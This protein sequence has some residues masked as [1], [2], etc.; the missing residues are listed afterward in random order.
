MHNAQNTELNVKR[1]SR[2]G[3]DQSV[4]NF[5]WKNRARGLRRAWCRSCQRI[6][7]HQHYLANAD[8]YKKRRRERGDNGRARVRAHVTEYLLQ[9]PCV[10]CGETSRGVLE[11]DHRDPAQKRL[12]VS[13]LAESGGWRSVLLEIEKC[14]VRCA[15][16]H[17]KR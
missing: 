3:I 6:Y 7:S 5:Q 9:H 11:F 8:A 1:C 2:C 17:R 10:D 12:A 15:N 13:R 4:E 16:C 14:E